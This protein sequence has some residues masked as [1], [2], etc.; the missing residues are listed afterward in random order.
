MTAI[1]L[2]KVT[3]RVP[4]WLSSLLRGQLLRLQSG[5]F[6]LSQPANDAWEATGARCAAARERDWISRAAAHL[7]ACRS[8]VGREKRD[9]FAVVVSLHHVYT[10]GQGVPTSGRASDWLDI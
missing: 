2:N 7:P 10:R 5:P 4:S 9:C 6:F 3:A 8:L 1:F